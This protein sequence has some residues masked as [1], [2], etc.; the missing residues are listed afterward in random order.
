MKYEHSLH[1]VLLSHGGCSCVQI[2]HGWCLQTGPSAQ[3]RK[4][5]WRPRGG[6]R[7]LLARGW[8]TQR[9]LPAASSRAHRA[10]TSRPAAPAGLRAAL[11]LIAGVG[12]FSVFITIFL[13]ADLG[14]LPGSPS[15]L[16]QNGLH[17][18]AI[19][20]P[21]SATIAAKLRGPLVQWREAVLTQV[22][23]GPWPF[24]CSVNC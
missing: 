3:R 24:D 14:A 9:R 6:P 16:L 13:T 18:S 5:R 2:W 20:Q 21:I 11:L 23:C 10:P 17:Y 22:I 7:P 1:A 8:M 4:L 15:L 12:S 19:L